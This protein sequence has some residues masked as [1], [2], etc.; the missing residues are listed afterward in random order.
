MDAQNPMQGA[1][2]GTAIFAGISVILKVIAAL[3]APQV[4]RS[5]V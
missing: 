3:Q 5:A 4:T 2:V 1:D